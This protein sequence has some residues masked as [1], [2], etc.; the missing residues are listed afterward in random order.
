M[1]P[2]ATPTT[3][4]AL[5]TEAGRPSTRLAARLAALPQRRELELRPAFA[6]APT[7]ELPVTVLYFFYSPTASPLRQLGGR[8][9]AGCGHRSLLRVQF[10][11]TRS[12]PL[13]YL[14]GGGG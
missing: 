4:A 6:F 3:A 13:H 8:S 7:G 10:L 9:G 14:P 2:L 5:R 12:R 1:V 11:R